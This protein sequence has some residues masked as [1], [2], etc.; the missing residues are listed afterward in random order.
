LNLPNADLTDEQ[1]IRKGFDLKEVKLLY[2]KYPDDVNAFV[3]RSNYRTGSP[4][5]E[6]WAIYKVQK[7]ITNSTSGD[8]ELYGIYLVV[9]FVPDN[10]ETK[11][12]GIGC[13]GPSR[14]TPQMI[15]PILAV[16][17][18]NEMCFK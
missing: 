13:E 5:N 7:S 12:V 8:N 18:E 6:I 14:S 9:P 10:N 16:A 4:Y 11:A 1:L 17:I 3:D 15:S 2:T